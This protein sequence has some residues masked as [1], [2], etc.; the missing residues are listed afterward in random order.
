MIKPASFEWRE[1]PWER[2]LRAARPEVSDA[3]EKALAENDLGME[4]GLILA[5][6][7]RRRPCGAGQGCARDWGGVSS[8]IA[9][10]TW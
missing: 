6:G 9:S 3:L 10:P 1:I 7:R 8:G 2:A 5:E 4:E